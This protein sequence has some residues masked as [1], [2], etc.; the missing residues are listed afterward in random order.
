MAGKTTASALQTTPAVTSGMSAFVLSPEQEKVVNH[1]GGH[2]QVIACAG[3]EK[4]HQLLL[5]LFQLNH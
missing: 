5:T 2:L 1:R 4:H 3:A